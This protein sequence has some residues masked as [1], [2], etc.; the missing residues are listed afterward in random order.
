MKHL[1]K[2]NESSNSEVDHEYIKNC[3]IE[4]IDNGAHV[5][6]EDEEFDE[7]QEIRLVN[8]YGEEFEGLLS[9]IKIDIDGP[10]LE[11]TTIESYVSQS[12]ELVEFYLDI[13]NSINKV[14]LKYPDIEYEFNK[15]DDGDRFE[16]IFYTKE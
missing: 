13:E 8:I 9:Y 14:R 7:Y 16:I 10:E 6:T 3:F 11:D 15:G 12:K 5:Q 1:R 4:F 2:F